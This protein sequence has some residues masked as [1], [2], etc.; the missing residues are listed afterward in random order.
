MQRKIRI[1]NSRFEGAQDDPIN[2]HGTHLKVIAYEP[3]NKIVVRFMHP[4]SYGFEAFFPGDEV[5][6]TEIHSYN[7]CIKH[8]YSKWRE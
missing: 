5:E 3:G 7:V 2:V 6:F 8:Q 1:I 4:Q